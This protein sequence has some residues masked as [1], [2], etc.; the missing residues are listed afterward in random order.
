MPNDPN[1]SHWIRLSANYMDDPRIIKA[2]PQAELVFVRS[3]AVARRLMADGTLSTPLRPVVTRDLD[4]PGRIVAR[5]LE[6]GLWEETDTGWAIPFERW[7]RWQTTQEEYDR[8]RKL[9]RERQRR[10]RTRDQP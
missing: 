7:A 6:V 4:H 10:H 5:L 3:L 1:N 9:A 2:G 8:Q